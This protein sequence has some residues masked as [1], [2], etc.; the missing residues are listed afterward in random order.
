MALMSM[1]LKTGEYGQ[2]TIDL[3]R[4]NVALRASEQLDWPRA[5]G[6]SSLGDDQTSSKIR[7]SPLTA[8]LPQ[9]SVGIRL[10]IGR[11]GVDDLHSHA[12]VLH[13]CS[14]TSDASDSNV[15]LFRRSVGFSSGRLAHGMTM[16][17]SFTPYSSR[18]AT[19]GSTRVARTAGTRL[20]AAATAVISAATPTSV[21]GS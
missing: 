7:T 10:G 18:I 13:A 5:A 8:Q 4:R 21:A 17:R 2:K 3:C 20:A 19:I 9:T 15:C 12:N 11:P 14:S 6:R 16:A 1:R